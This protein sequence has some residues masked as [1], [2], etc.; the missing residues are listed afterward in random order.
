[1]ADTDN[2][3][4]LVDLM[5]ERYWD[6]LPMRELIMDNGSQFGAHRR[7]FLGQITCGG[8]GRHGS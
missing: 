6:I 2:S 3:I 1:M 5:V 4:L 7:G 8:K